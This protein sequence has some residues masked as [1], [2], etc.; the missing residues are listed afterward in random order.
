MVNQVVLVGAFADAM[1]SGWH[2]VRKPRYSQHLQQHG[3]CDLPTGHIGL[4]N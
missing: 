2:G 3:Y 1:D 4:P